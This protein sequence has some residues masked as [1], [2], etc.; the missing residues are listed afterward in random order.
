MKAQKAP[1]HKLLFHIRNKEGNN[2]THKRR[3]EVV[4]LAVERRL[5]IRRRRLLRTVRRL[6]RL[7]VVVSP[8]GGRSGHVGFRPRLLEP[9]LLA[10]R[11]I[12][13]LARR[14]VELITAN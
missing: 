4:H 11:P 5:S 9:S 6:S 8:R 3:L 7:L 1:T 14:R 13:Q 2:A 12:M 10:S